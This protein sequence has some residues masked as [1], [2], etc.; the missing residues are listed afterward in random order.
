MADEI[1]MTE[2]KTSMKESNQNGVLRDPL[3][4]ANEQIVTLQ[5]EEYYDVSS[6]VIYSVDESPP[7]LM[8]LLLGLQHYL[9]MFFATLTVPFLLSKAI[10][11]GTDLVGEAEMIGTLFVASGLI[12][13]I[14]TS[15]GVRLPI[16]QAGTF[17][18]LAPTLAYFELDKWQCP[19]NIRSGEWLAANSNETNADGWIISGTEDHQEVWMSRLR[20]IQGAIII[21]AMFE[22]VLG[23]TGV[24]GFLLRFIG[25]LTIFPTV[26]LLGLQMVVKTAEYGAKHWGICA[27][28][29]ILIALFSQYL[30][31]FDVPCI[32]YTKERGLHKKKYPLF[33][34]FPIMLG[35]CISWVTCYALT[36]SDVLPSNSTES[37]YWARTDL[38]ADAITSSPWFRIPYP[39][40]WGVPTFSIAAVCAIFSGILA[41]IIE[42]V[43]DYHACAKLA[44]APPPP[45]H[46]IN[47]GILVEGLGSLID[48]IL[49]TGN[50]TTSTSI[51]VGVVGISKVG[52][53][54]VVQCSAIFM[55]TLG[56]FTKF[57]AI[58]IT[59]PEPVIGA[60]F[61]VLF[62][63]IV[64]VGIS[65]LQHVD[66][67]SGRNLFIIGFSLFLGLSLPFWVADHKSSINTSV[68]VLDNVLAVLLSTSMFV[69]GLVG[70]VLD[71][72]ISGTKEERGLAYWEKAR[73]ALN[74]KNTSQYLRKRLED[75][76]DLPFGNNF[77]RRYK[78]TT[79]IPFLPT[80]KSA[81]F[82]GNSE[83]RNSVC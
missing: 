7:L 3:L 33:K 82:Q 4:T 30:G 52:S 67:N 80:Y 48:G 74:Q 46:A 23:A 78:W 41:T 31:R 68:P 24:I 8:C 56:L 66:M 77:L 25:P 53:R 18:L 62:S 21:A 6:D 59:I 54:R 43:G 72:T 71:N 35:M 16:V 65:N 61:F 1:K 49:G 27:F 70:F 47:R 50:G 51:N 29:M 45:L 57:G 26:T 83:N 36:V 60:A 19:D 81:V 10:C 20:E 22:L 79:Y 11:M 40:Q 38:N 34:M 76:Y 12:T 13:L 32:N 42:S 15:I 63:M 44:G 58:F 37:G 14:Q 69:G 5:E 39:G 9:S 28:T 17:A 75:C 55:I 2:Q 64:A 73:Q